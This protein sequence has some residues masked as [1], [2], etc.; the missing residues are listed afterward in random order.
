MQYHLYDIKAALNRNHW[1][2][3]SELPGND[4]E[5]S[6]VW[7][8]A[9]PNGSNLLHIEF[10]G[11]DDMKTL[12]I[13]RAYGIKIREAPDIGVYFSRPSRSWITELEQFISKLEQYANN[14]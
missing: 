11:L 10:Q 2:V 6:A 9:R 3:V 13:D 7:Q 8:I 4:Y 5:V 1:E 14:Q 12:P